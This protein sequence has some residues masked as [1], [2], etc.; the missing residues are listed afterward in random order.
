VLSKGITLRNRSLEPQTLVGLVTMRMMGYSS[1]GG[2]GQ[3]AAEAG[4]LPR[5]C[6][7]LREVKLA[8]MEP[9]AFAGAGGGLSDFVA[10]LRAAVSVRVG[11]AVVRLNRAGFTHSD[12]LYQIRDLLA[13]G[14]PIDADA[15]AW[16]DRAIAAQGERN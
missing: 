9:A 14:Q 1:A 13:A 4:S 5:I 12:R 2:G 3:Y 15:L 7:L 6:Q 16:L 11:S 10:D 8:L